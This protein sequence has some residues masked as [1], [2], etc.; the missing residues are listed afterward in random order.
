MHLDFSSD[1]DEGRGRE[2][3]NDGVS[4]ATTTTT[5]YGLPTPSLHVTDYLNHHLLSL[6][7]KCTYVPV[8]ETPVC[9]RRPPGTAWPVLSGLPLSTGQAARY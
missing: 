6:L 1:E 5:R 7:E 4:M 9:T 3:R 8:R 2:W